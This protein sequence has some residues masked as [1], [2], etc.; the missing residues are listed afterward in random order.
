LRLASMTDLGSWDFYER[1]KNKRFVNYP[2]AGHHPFHD[3]VDWAWHMDPRSIFEH[4]RRHR[5]MVGNPNPLQ[6]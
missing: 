1:N 4:T 5:L 6:S 3:I 2:I